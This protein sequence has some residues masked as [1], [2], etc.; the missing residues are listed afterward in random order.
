[1]SKKRYERHQSQPNL[2]E[3]KPP[4]DHCKVSWP[5]VYLVRIEPTTEDANR[6]ADEKTY[7]NR[8]LTVA[9]FLNWITLLAAAVA[10]FGLIYLRGQLTQMSNSNEISK[11]ALVSV[12]R[13]FVVF[14]GAILGAKVLDST[15][16]RAV[17]MRVN[18]PWLNSGSTPTKDALSQVNWVSL[19]GGLP[20]NF[21]YQDLANIPKSQFALGPKATGNTTLYVPIEFFEA[22]RQGK[23]RLFFYGWLTYRDIFSGTPLRLSEF[24]NE[25]INVK[26]NE[27][28]S[29]ANASATWEPS[30][31]PRHN[32]YDDQCADYASHMFPNIPRL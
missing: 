8:Q 3:G 5:S 4:S 22:A 27:P 16:R 21:I 11:E 13:A 15:G 9:K 28:M 29:D 12:Q 7:R 30:L 19:P 14:S 25:I 10:L 32:C 6:S 1:L 17:R 26:S 31:C 23:T 24:C 2:H 20:D 18:T